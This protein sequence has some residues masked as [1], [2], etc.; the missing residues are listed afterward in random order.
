MA[1]IT[2]IAAPAANA[3][4]LLKR[5]LLIA[6]ASRLGVFVTAVVATYVFHL[7]G[8]LQR[9]R[10]PHAALPFA[11]V[12]AHLV[13]AWGNW[14]GA[15][16]IRI[17]EHGYAAANNTAAFS[18]LL[19]LCVRGLGAALGGEYLVAGI[20]IALAAYFAAV[21]VLYRFVALDL[22]SRVAF[23]SVVFISIF[24][25]AFF[26]QAVY[27]EAP[28]LLLTLS[29]LYWSRTARWWPAGL[30]GL[31]AVLTR[32]S[33]V[34]LVVPMAVYYLQQCG[35][36]WRRANRRLAAL[37]LVPLGLALWIVYL[38][39]AFGQPLLFAR[40]QGHWRRALAFPLVT[41]WR[42]AETAVNG[43]RQVLSGQSV[44]A[45]FPIQPGAN[46]IGTAIENLI[47]FVLLLGVVALF[48]YGL[49]RL[50]AA[51]SAWTVLAA[52]YP[53]FFPG[54]YVPLSSYARFVLVA[55]PLFVSVAVLCERR[56]RLRAALVALS[57]GGLI[58]LTGMFAVYAWVA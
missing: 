8:A 36:R 16:Y 48:V 45:Y 11:G 28:F 42:A 18:P 43:A 17:A 20:V 38:A 37:A 13:N 21:V 31:L 23:W 4:N 6:A 2:A 51:Y 52:G 47:A 53:L 54:R 50:P 22:G 34:L 35:W 12:A 46:V 40:A 3:P 1:V 7:G 26:F 55:F 44:H 33:A 56:P 57:L 49:R 25:T 9:S 30:A 27:T 39:T 41:P 32:T 19:P 14:D 5:A 10:A 15:W 24:P 58:A 29:C